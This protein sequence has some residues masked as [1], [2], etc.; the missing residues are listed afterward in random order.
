MVSAISESPCC[1]KP[2]V[3]FLFKRMYGLEDYVDLR[4]PRLLFGAW[5]SFMCEWGDFGYSESP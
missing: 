4:S 2:F 5:P 3:K 1:P